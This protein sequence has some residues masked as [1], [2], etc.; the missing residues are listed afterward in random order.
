MGKA[1]RG[2]VSQ[3]YARARKTRSKALA[4]PVVAGN[5][6]FATAKGRRKIFHIQGADGFKLLKR[7]LISGLFSHLPFI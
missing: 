3:F 2:T 6:F 1:I 4:H 5:R 7:A